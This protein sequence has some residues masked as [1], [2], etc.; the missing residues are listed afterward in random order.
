MSVGINL[1]HAFVTGP[2]LMYVGLARKR[3]SWVFHVLVAI[4]VLLALYFPYVIMTRKLSQYHVW[5]FIHLAIFIPLLI[6]IGVMKDR[7]PKILFSLVL[8]IGIAA[9]GYHLIRF[10]QHYSSS[11]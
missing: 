2:F 1:A 3:P 10:Y 9:I 11:S 6:A 8:A 5:L 4:G 7:A